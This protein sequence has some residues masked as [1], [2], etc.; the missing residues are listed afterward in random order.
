MTPR[1]SPEGVNH[2][3][4]LET[5]E[6][7]SWTVTSWVWNEKFLNQYNTGNLTVTFSNP[8][9]GFET[10]CSGNGEELKPRRQI[11]QRQVMGVCSG[12]DPV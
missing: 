12:S 8:A 9:T 7:P 1:V 11:R 6:T 3:N 2:P 4:C 5:S 10:R